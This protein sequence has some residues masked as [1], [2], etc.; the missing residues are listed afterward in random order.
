MSKTLLHRLFGFGSVPKAM[1]PILD[2]EG[3]VL[4]DEGIGGS[5]TF[6]NFRAP[7]KRYGYRKNWFTGSLVITELRFAGFAFSRP[8]IN[9]PLE[10]AHSSKLEC[11]LEK[12]RTILRVA[13]D[14]ADFHEDWSG[15][16]ECRFRTPKA[17]QF[18]ERIETSTR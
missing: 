16:I 14:S 3:I 7:G 17:R 8:V 1:K 6:R 4:L 15:A 11:S 18:L 9:V 2:Q 10:G 12:E 5:I 13:F